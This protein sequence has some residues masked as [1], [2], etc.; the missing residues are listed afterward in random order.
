MTGV[1][2]S[3]TALVGLRP[4]PASG[5]GHSATI[6]NAWRFKDVAF[7]VQSVTERPLAHVIAWLK[8]LQRSGVP[9][10][11]FPKKGNAHSYTE[12]DLVMLCML[13]ALH[14]VGVPGANA[15]DLLIANDWQRKWR[16]GESVFRASSKSGASVTL[17]FGIIAA[18]IEAHRPYKTPLP[19]PKPRKRDVID[20]RKPRYRNPFAGKPTGPIQHVPLKGKR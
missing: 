20:V 11:S 13:E 7:V 9:K 10:G 1:S 15:V 18:A 5:L 4:E 3:P 8:Q 12:D 6:T 16:D 17:D 14:S 19:Q 2:A